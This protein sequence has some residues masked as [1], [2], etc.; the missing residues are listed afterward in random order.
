[1]NHLIS[2]EAFYAHRASGMDAACGDANLSAQSEAIAICESR[3]S[4]VEHTGAV[5]LT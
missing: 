2:Q 1:M 3:R 5:H 4:I